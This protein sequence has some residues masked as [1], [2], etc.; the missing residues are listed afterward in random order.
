MR[1][2]DESETMKALMGFASRWGRVAMIAAAMT[3]SAAA[4]MPPL[5]A[6]ATLDVSKYMGRWYQVALYPNRFQSDCAS[7]TEARYTLLDNGDVTVLNQCRTQ[8][9]SMDTAQ[10][11]AQAATPVSSGQ[12]SPAQLKVSFLPRWLRWTGWGWGNYWVVQLADDY[13][14]A[15][16]SE[17][18]RQFLWVLSR[19][20]AMKPQ[21][22][23]DV[24]SYLQRNGFDLARVQRHSQSSR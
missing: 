13:R 6:V 1:G 9:G 16:V 15:V 22:E 21:D 23:A 18:T 19:T 2:L 3:Q 17:P 24:F 8:N 10:G 7:D 20:P 14:Y 11:I 4:D 5:K 12:L